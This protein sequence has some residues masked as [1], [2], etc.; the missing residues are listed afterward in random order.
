MKRELVE[1][2]G[3]PGLARDISSHAVINTDKNKLMEARERKRLFLEKELKLEN[4]ISGMET[5]ISEIR[6][7]LKKLLLKKEPN[8]V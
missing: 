7:L 8:V 6:D 2:D 1:I 5:D 3:K 4:R